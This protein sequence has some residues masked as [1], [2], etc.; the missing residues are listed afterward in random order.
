MATPADFAKWVRPFVPN[1]P[2]PILL[3]AIFNA[4]VEYCSRTQNLTDDVQITTQAG[5]STYPITVLDGYEPVQI[6][7]VKRDGYPLRP[8]DRRDIE[9]KTFAA[10]RQPTD[11]YMDGDFNL[12]LFPTPVDVDTFD[13]SVAITPAMDATELPDLLLKQQRYLHVAAGAKAKLLV[14][15]YPWANL[16]VAMYE[17]EVFE[18][19]IAKQQVKRSKGNSATRLRTKTTFF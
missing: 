9:V 1:C 19:A 13:L 4:A 5:V 10:P 11:F 7:T 3:D 15:P 2:E 17:L 18:S 6:L 8:S 16:Q 14:E 12:V